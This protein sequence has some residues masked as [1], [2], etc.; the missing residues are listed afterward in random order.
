MPVNLKGNWLQNTPENTLSF[1]VQYTQPLADDYHLVARM[2]Y[3]WQSMMFG[4]IFNTAPD[5]IPSWDVMNLQLTLNSPDE[6]WYVTG[7][8]K[9]VMDNNNLT[10]MYLTSP[11]SGL[12]T[13]EFYGDPRTYGITVGIHM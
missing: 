4:S 6:T 13:N 2:D 3:Y 8:V 10:G 1:G 11:T 7:F 12:Y 9:N 5:K